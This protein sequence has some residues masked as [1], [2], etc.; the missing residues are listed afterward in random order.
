MKGKNETKTTSQTC[1]NSLYRTKDLNRQFSFTFRMITFIW[2]VQNKLIY[3]EG[4]LVVAG[5]Q[6]EK[7]TE[8]VNLMMW[9]S[10]GKWSKCCRVRQQWSIC[11]FVNVK[12]PL[13]IHIKIVSY[14]MS[15]PTLCDPM[16]RQV[17]LSLEFLEY[18]VVIP[19]SRG[20]PGD[21]WLRDRTWVS[22]IAGRFFTIWVT[23]EA[24]IM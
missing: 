12:S 15:Y 6:E 23:R 17:L 18:W 13:N 4:R 7:E 24:P 1:W 14:V 19:F 16:D 9:G 10:F 22:C 2:N 11:N 3:R 20:S 21:P 8:S 5:G